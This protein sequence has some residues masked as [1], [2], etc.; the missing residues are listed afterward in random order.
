MKKIMVLIALIVLLVI[1]AGGL[2]VW[3]EMQQPLYEPGMVR[4]GQNLRGPLAPPAQPSDDSYWL[5]EGDIRLHHF[6][7]GAGTNVLVIHGGPGHP[8]AVPLPGLGPLTDEYRFIYYDQRGCGQSSRPIDAFSSRNYYQ[9]LQVLDRTLGLGAQIADVERIR[10]IL[11]DDKLVIIGHSFGGFL[12][13]LYAAE[14]PEHVRALIL[15]APAD[16]LVMP[17]ES[18]GLFE[19]VRTWLPG[20]MQ[21]EYDAYL[22]RYLDY[23]TIFS[24]TETELA[25]LNLEFVRYYGAAAS[26]KGFNLPLESEPA[27]GGGWMVHAMYFS[28]GLRHDYRAALRQV[29]VPVLIIHGSRDLQPEETSRLYATAF[30]NSAFQVIPD[31]GHFPFSEQPEEFAGVVDNFLRSL[32]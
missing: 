5:V 28:L 7:V 13:S 19:Q 1:G 2:Y 6:S 29:D 16:L 22:K 11:G 17:P 30:P 27:D 31:A 21:A 25:S 24:K 15:V 3:N 32:K 8:F 14:F 12:A 9:N 4:A 18:G 23:G 26:Q 10:R 20:E